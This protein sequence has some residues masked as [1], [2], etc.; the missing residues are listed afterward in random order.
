MKQPYYPNLQ[1]LDEIHFVGNFSSTISLGMSINI[2]LFLVFIKKF[3]GTTTTIISDSQLQKSKPSCLDPMYTVKECRHMNVHNWKNTTSFIKPETKTRLWS[4]K[5][6]RSPQM[7][8][9]CEL[10]EVIPILQ[11]L[12]VQ[13]C[14]RGTPE[15]KE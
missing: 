7:D 3:K 2:S 11:V 13:V 15:R 12:H 10:S 6:N 4:T 9:T 1:K 8:S 14:R 5:P